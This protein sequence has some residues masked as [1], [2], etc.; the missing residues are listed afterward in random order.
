MNEDLKKLGLI[1]VVWVVWIVYIWLAALILS[2]PENSW[3]W[4]PAV[5]TG[6]VLLIGA[7]L[8]TLFIGDNL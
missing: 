5:I 8:G 4:V 3:M 2:V 7:V 6:L 1:A